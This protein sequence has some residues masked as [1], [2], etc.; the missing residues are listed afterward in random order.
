MRMSGA[1]VLSMRNPLAH[2]TSSNGWCM[3]DV[4]DPLKC[5]W[6]KIALHAMCVSIKL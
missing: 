2:L 6:L 3:D 5:H 1:I 4:C